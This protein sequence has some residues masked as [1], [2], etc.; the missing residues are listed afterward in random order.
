[1]NTINHG[2]RAGTV[3]ASASSP[4]GASPLARLYALNPKLEAQVKADPG[5]R[6]F[7]ELN[8]D[9]LVGFEPSSPPAGAARTNVAFDTWTHATTL[10]PPRVR[11]EEFIVVIARG[12]AYE[13]KKDV[14]IPLQSGGTGTSDG[15][16]AYVGRSGDYQHTFVDDKDAHYP[17]AGSIQFPLPVFGKPGEQVELS[18]CRIK[19]DAQGRAHPQHAAWPDSFDG[20]Y[21]GYAGR[22]RTVTV[23]PG[24]SVRLKNPD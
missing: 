20:V 18:Y 16:I 11:D 3:G 24:A 7:L 15:V 17:G 2:V 4:A 1:M 6:A 10:V 14:R 19:P 12:S 21:G 9:V 22:D 23:Q 13:S 8:R 5:L